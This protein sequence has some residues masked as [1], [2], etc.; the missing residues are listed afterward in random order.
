MM[1]ALYVLVACA[2]VAA[3]IAFFLVRMAR[4]RG[5]RVITCP[6]NQQTAAV[7]VDAT[8]AT[9]SSIFRGDTQYQL[10]TCSRWPEKEGCGQEC[11]DEIE[12]SPN[13]CLVRA[14]L[15]DW[16]LGRACSF[17]GR[18]FGEINWHDHKPG[19]F[20]PKTNANLDWTQ[21]RPELVY[22]A[23]ATHEPVCW[24]CNVAERF[25]AEHPD[26]VVDRHRT[27]V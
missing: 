19:L 1:T 21:V 17:C 4:M 27:A 2:V 5:P 10:T 8:R 12:S 16:Y 3:A 15:A 23:L 24:N 25:R 13:H 7:E 14:I 9:L 11:V 22:A 18:P 6:E 26:L 20:D